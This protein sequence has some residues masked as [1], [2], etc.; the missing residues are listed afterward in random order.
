MIQRHSFVF[1]FLNITVPLL[2]GLFLYVVF[3]PDTIISNAIYG[4]L[5]LTKPDIRA[6]S[7]LLSE[8]IFFL[9]CYS[10]DMLWAYSLTF[11]CSAIIGTSARQLA[12]T[13]II[14]FSFEILIELLQNYGVLTGV[15]DFLDIILE[16]ISTLLAVLIIII[17]KKIKLG[18]IV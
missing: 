13:G 9:R 17:H 7:S 1:W 4:L 3:R 2:I 15:F 11:A 16:I 12:V 18:T 5:Q 8:V 14:C 6:N 10:C